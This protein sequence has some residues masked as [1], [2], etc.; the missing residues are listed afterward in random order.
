MLK[1]EGPTLSKS[2]RSRQIA[3]ELGQLFQRRIEMTKCEALT[4]LTPQQRTEYGQIEARIDELF[5]ERA[6]LDSHFG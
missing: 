1:S 6:K 3:I 4:G 2:D 5:R